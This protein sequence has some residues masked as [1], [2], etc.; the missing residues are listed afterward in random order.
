MPAASWPGMKGGVGLTGQSPSAACRSVWQTPHA[1]TF[2]RISPG[3]G[4]GTGTHSIASGLPNSRT[5]AAFI[6]LFVMTIILSRCLFGGMMKTA[7]GGALIHRKRPSMA[8][9]LT[10]FKS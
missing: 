4:T 10:A 8:F 1:T 3:P 5:T 2:T 9:E 7:P 6:S